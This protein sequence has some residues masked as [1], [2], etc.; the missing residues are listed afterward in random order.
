MLFCIYVLLITCQGHTFM[1]STTTTCMHPTV[2]TS[3]QSLNHF[4][5]IYTPFSLFLLL[6]LGNQPTLA[7]KLRIYHNTPA[8]HCH[9]L[10]HNSCSLYSHESS[11]FLCLPVLSN[12]LASD[13]NPALNDLTT[14]ILPIFSSRCSPMSP[15]SY[16][17]ISARRVSMQSECHSPWLL[18]G[19]C[20]YHVYMTSLYVMRSLWCTD[21]FTSCA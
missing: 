18:P 10:P 12:H 8:F 1:W 4:L 16:P 11:I 5:F 17:K 19:V 6:T 3:K 9:N 2:P 15:T 13:H 20:I 14:K 21:N 7:L